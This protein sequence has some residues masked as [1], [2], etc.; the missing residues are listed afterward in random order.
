MITVITIIKTK[1]KNAVN[2]LSLEDIV[3]LLLILI[4]LNL[5]NFIIPLINT[6]Y[7]ILQETDENCQSPY[8]EYL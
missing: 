4:P 7:L 2:K 5:V 3:P 1:T 6:L 8:L